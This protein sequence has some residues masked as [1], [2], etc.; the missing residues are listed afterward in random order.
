M[1]TPVPCFSL[2]FFL[3]RRVVCYSFVEGVRL[4]NSILLASCSRARRGDGDEHVSWWLSVPNI[5][6][7]IVHNYFDAV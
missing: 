4:L 3:V 6:G 2:S 7:I 5:D 1:S